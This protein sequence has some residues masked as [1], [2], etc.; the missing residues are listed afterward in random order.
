MKRFTGGL[1]TPAAVD[2][3]FRALKEGEFRS[4]SIIDLGV[5]EFPVDDPLNILAGCGG[6][7]IQPFRCIIADSIS[8]VDAS[9]GLVGRELRSGQIGLRSSEYP[10]FKSTVEAVSEN[11][12]IQVSNPG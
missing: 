1:F 10:G 11:G 7:D 3:D 6:S 9:F 5:E 4:Q 2:I 12:S 8:G